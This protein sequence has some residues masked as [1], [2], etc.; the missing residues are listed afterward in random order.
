MIMEDRKASVI[1]LI[2]DL[3]E[4]FYDTPDKFFVA[5]VRNLISDG[6]SDEDIRRMVGRT[7]SSHTKT[8][9]TIADVINN[10]ARSEYE[11]YV[12]G[13]RAYG[14]K[15]NPSFL[16]DEDQQSAPPRPGA[17]YYWNVRTHCWG[18]C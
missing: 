3:K 12:S 10:A 1:D 17:G 2:S 13:K 4:V 9:L 16:P 6:F 5:L 11:F 7:V 18:N 8:R 14:D 15:Y